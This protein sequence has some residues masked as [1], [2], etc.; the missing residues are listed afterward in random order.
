MSI[1]G[2]ALVSDDQTIGVYD[3][4]A[5]DYA[6]MVDTV[7]DPA[8]DRL[9][10]ETP[11]GG[12]VLDLGCGPGTAAAIMSKAGLAVTA[13]DASAEMVRLASAI[14]GITVRQERF[15][16]LTGTDTYD[17]IWASF[18]LLHAPRADFP[19]H[20]AAMKRA[21]KPG[22][23]LYLGMKLG[24]GEK[25]DTLGRFYSYYGEDELTELLTQA[26]FAVQ[27]TRTFTVKGLAGSPEPCIAVAADG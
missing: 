18:S 19:G 15:D 3:A 27:D 7:S 13:V 20:L 17:A 8:L 22:G 12:Q 2:G 9:I 1:G 23:R 14:P 25:T 24:N 16:E 4:R 10:A 11:K 21:L 6:R 5:E 26:G